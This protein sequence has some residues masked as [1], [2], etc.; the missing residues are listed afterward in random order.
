[1]YRSLSV[2]FAAMLLSLITTAQAKVLFVDDNDKITENS[3]AMQAALDAAYR[4]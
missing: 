4:P 3:T 2:A 1:M